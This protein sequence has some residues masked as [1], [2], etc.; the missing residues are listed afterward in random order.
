MKSYWE[1][2]LRYLKKYKSKTF[3]I[4]VGI[5][6]SIALIISILI[7]KEQLIET[8]K[9]SLIDGIGGVYDIKLEST[10]KQAMEKLQKDILVNKSSLVNHFGKS[11]IENTNYSLSIEGFEENIIDFL[12]FKN[13][14]GRY[15]TKDYEIALENWV[16]DLLPRKYN[17]GDKITLT[18]YVQASDNL[19]NKEYRTDEFTLVGT[20]DYIY[21][22]N[23]FK[24]TAYGYVTRAFAE[25][26]GK[27]NSHQYQGYILLK[28]NSSLYSGMGQLAQTPDYSNISFIDN[29]FKY[30]T[31]QMARLYTSIC[32]TLFLVVSVVASIIIYNIFNITVTERK[33]EFGILRAIGATPRRVKTMVILEGIILG[34]IFIPC[35]ILIGNIITKGILVKLSNASNFSGIFA[36]SNQGIVISI[37]I[38]FL[39]IIL[40]SYSP[41]KKASNIPPMEAINSMGDSYKRRDRGKF[42]IDTASKVSKKVNFTFNFAKINIKRNKKR[43]ITTVMSLAITVIMFMI[44]Q[45]ITTSIDSVKALKESDHGDITITGNSFEGISQ[46]ALSEIANMKGIEI[47]NKKMQYNAN[48]C[49]SDQYLTSKGKEY[50]VKK[51]GNSTYDA[52]L[53]EKGKYRLESVVYGYSKEKLESLRKDVIEGAID[54]EKMNNDASVVFIQ[55]ANYYDYTNLA[56]GDQI[57]V[58]LVL[59]DAEGNFKGNKVKNLTIGAIVDPIKVSS[60]I[61]SGISNALIISEEAFK[62]EIGASGYSEVKL[63]IKSNKTTKEYKEAILKNLKDTSNIEIT[64]F[65]EQLEKAKETNLQ[66][67]AAFYS[68]LIFV[69]LVSVV[70]LFQVMKMNTLLRKKEFGM[71][72]ALGM[73]IS[74]VN[75]MIRIEGLLYGIIASIIG[76]S[77]GSFFTYIIY[78]KGKR[79]LQI[80][81]LWTFPIT[82]IIIIASIT[83]LITVISSKGTSKKLFKEPIVE[84]IKNIE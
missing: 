46:E 55:N 84:L 32:N 79:F 57:E 35:G 27:E 83:I 54:L 33:K 19:G 5:T 30:S 31:E 58:N 14:K 59:L 44:I 63:G 73:S 21:N 48:I 16:L 64:T 82:T 10:D 66:T 18:S 36:I 23:Y 6:I 42:N 72:R 76:C 22:N 20:F 38:G 69:A 53:M 81:T 75:K 15:P 67:N 74:Q 3:S 25:A 51:A 62:K 2:S 78:E 13:L 60:E 1:I 61:S 47:L 77:F 8:T 52:G 40:G 28:E 12:N 45:Y 9:T 11:E 26:Q 39:F 4:A 70:N 7:I 49:I 68:F 29:N 50:A 56:V 80:K 65:E 41:A 24:N 37:I 71:L 34:F 43:F 17:I